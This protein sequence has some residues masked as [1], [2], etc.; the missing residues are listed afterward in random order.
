MPI[1][2]ESHPKKLHDNNQHRHIDKTINS[3]NTAVTIYEPQGHTTTART[4]RGRTGW[5]PS[6]ARNI[7]AWW[8]R[9]RKPTLPE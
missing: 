4:T 6:L 8:G 2:G 5:K 3:T 9:E 1:T 7:T